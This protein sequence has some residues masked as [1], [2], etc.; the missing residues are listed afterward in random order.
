VKSIV[1]PD[2][3]RPFA[4][5][6]VVAM[7]LSRVG[8]HLVAGVTEPQS[9][10]IPMAERPGRIPAAEQ[11]NLIAVFN[12]G[13][14]ALHGQY[15]MMLDGKAFLPPRDIAC[16][17]G[18]YRDGSLRIRTWPNISGTQSD[19][20]AYR[21]TPPCLVEQ[22][23][24]NDKLTESTKNWG[25]TV[26][27][28]TIIRRS[29]IGVDASGKVLF[30]AL[31]EAVSAQA[32]ARA[33]QAVGARDAA[34]LDVNYAYPRFLFFDHPP[35]AERKAVMSLVPHVD[36]RSSDY[37]RDASPRDFFYVTRSSP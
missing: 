11:P 30:Y 26:S 19:M 31:G 17:V 35:A 9:E 28:E 1:H 3:K 32:L 23:V 6:A 12:G 21:Q 18:L 22:G 27:G 14:K 20:V 4:A 13:F 36:Y 16:T 25:A 24:L 29:A 7:D 2:K 10:K 8:L 37:V 15:G 34:Q 5:V 33:M